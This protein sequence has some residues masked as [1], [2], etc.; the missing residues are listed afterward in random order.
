[1]SDDDRMRVIVREEIAA[2]MAALPSV[3]TVQWLNDARNRLGAQ[4]GAV[5]YI[6]GAGEAESTSDAALRVV[7]GRDALREALKSTEEERDAAEGSRDSAM[8][9][10]DNLVAHYQTPAKT[11]RSIDPSDLIHRRYKGPQ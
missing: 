10:V 3:A 4:I 5:R 9:C 8:A 7:H 11:P 2:A 6:L 1:M